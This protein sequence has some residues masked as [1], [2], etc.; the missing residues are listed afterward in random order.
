MFFQK[1]PESLGPRTAMQ[2][3]FKTLAFA[4]RAAL[5]RLG[6]PRSRPAPSSGRSPELP[7][8]SVPHLPLI[9]ITTHPFCGWTSYNGTTQHILQPAGFFP[10]TLCCCGNVGRLCCRALWHCMDITKSGHPPLPMGL[11]VTSNRGC[12]EDR[13]NG[14]SQT[15][16]MWTPIHFSGANT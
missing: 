12:Y 13:G 10:S 2:V 6:F 1:R 9:P 4:L 7:I 8:Q 15:D 14:R 16:S 5:S 3:T 11:W